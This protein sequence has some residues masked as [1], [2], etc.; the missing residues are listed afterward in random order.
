MKM[1]FE[2]YDAKIEEFKNLP[3]PVVS[4]D[5]GITAADIERMRNGGDKYV[6][7]LMY[8]STRPWYRLEDAQPKEFENTDALESSEAAQLIDDLLYELVELVDELDSESK[9]D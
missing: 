2:S 6:P 4:I 1:T 3:N 5:Y 9:E 8:L 7:Y